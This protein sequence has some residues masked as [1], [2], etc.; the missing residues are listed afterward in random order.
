V[1]LV[2]EEFAIFCLVAE[3]QPLVSFANK[4]R[5][6][7]PLLLID[8]EL[9]NFFGVLIF[10]QLF[11]EGTAPIQCEYNNQSQQDNNANL[12]HVHRFLSPFSK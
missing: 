11:S 9:S 7:N 8:N 4:R 5:Y 1:K 2:F 10:S 6:K 3:S 12:S